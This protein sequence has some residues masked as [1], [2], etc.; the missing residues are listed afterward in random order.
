MSIRNEDPKP[1]IAESIKHARWRI[2]GTALIAIGLTVC[3]IHLFNATRSPRQQL[4]L[5]P[6][7][8]TSVVD[9]ARKDT[10]S[11][12]TP[13]PQLQAETPAD[14]RVRR[15]ASLSGGARAPII[16]PSGGG[17]HVS[18]PNG[19][20]GAVACGDHTITRVAND[21]AVV[22]A[23]DG[24]SYSVSEQGTMR[25]E[26]TTWSTGD[27]VTVCRSGS[28][29]SLYN[30]GRNEKVQAT[31]VGSAS[32]TQVACGDYTITR[33]ANEGA[34]VDA[35]DG[36]SYSVSEQGTMRIEVTTWSTGD[37]VTVCRSGSS[38]SLDNTG[39]NEKVQATAVGSA[40]STQVA[41][42]DHTIT[43][44]ANEGAVVE[45]SD[46][47]AYSVSEQGT[48]RIEVTTW[49]TGDRVTVCRSGSS[50]SLDN[51]GR[52]EKVQATRL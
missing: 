10:Q 44:V 13:L 46:G 43:R 29:A 32:S 51:T 22:D 11:S 23:S 21:G 35:S 19:A 4:S 2:Q 27:G 25:I 28:S 16:T 17:L 20:N 3:L 31:A 7:P 39:R 18:N 45:T 48:M 24:A 30:A 49:S 8:H 50:A 36:T 40:S 34:V 1:S 37:R 41:C 15:E 42:G 5:P 47:A 33:V 38:A 6:S 9:F 52:N 12:E 26:V 14:P